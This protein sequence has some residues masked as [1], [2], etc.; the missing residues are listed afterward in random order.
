MARR[1]TLV[2]MIALASCQAMFSVAAERSRGALFADF[3][4][5]ASSEPVPIDDMV[6][7]WDGP[8]Q[9]GEHA[10]ADARF[11]F[12]VEYDGWRLS[13]DQ[14]WYYYLE[15]SKNTS[16]FFNALE[17]GNA[18]P[19]AAVDLEAWSFWS[20]GV[21]LAKHWQPAE[22]WQLTPSVSLYRIGHYQFG[23]LQGFVEGGQTETDLTASA[24][25]D[26]H[27]DD[28][29]ILDYQND[30]ER[31]IGTSLSLEADYEFRPGWSFDVELRDLLNQQRFDQAL[32]TEGCI[33]FGSPQQPV[34]DALGS[35]SGRSGSDEFQTRIPLTLDMALR[36]K[37]AGASLGYF[38]H[39]RYRKLSIQQRWSLAGQDFAVLLSSDRQ[40]GFGWYSR[41]HRL[42]L[43]SD[44]SSRQR[45]RDLSL[46][47]GLRLPF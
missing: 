11:S 32:F 14:R 8:F 40:L 2:A 39:G 31:G 42:S 20:H 9:S 44:D 47:L 24:A 43:A 10:Y 34:C 5:Q 46:T 4:M 30:H 36:W 25:L 19:S 45:I 18:L 38:Q 1:F 12:G 23:T 22:H 21:T 6:S 15:F 16:R 27:F 7:G 26:Y 13:R 3:D 41:Y 33:E 17:R 37:S 29:K 28:D 35:A